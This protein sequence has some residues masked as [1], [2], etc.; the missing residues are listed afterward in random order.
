MDTKQI[1]KGSQAISRLQENGKF[2]IET[3]A[4]DIRMAGFMG[5]RGQ[6]S[7]NMTI[8]NILNGTAYQYR[9]NQGIYGFKAVNTAW[10]PSLDSSIANLNPSPVIGTDVITI[11]GTDQAGIALTQSMTSLTDTPQVGVNTL[12]NFGDIVMLSDCNARTVFQIT[13]SSPQA[14]GLLTHAVMSSQTPGN[15]STNLQ[16]LYSAD[17]MAYRMNARTY[18]IG[19]SA[20]HLG[21]YSLWRYCVPACYG[22]AQLEEIVDGVDDITILYGVDTDGDGSANKYV[23]AD[24]VNSANQWGFVSS[25][26]IQAL[27]STVQD[28]IVAKAQSYTYAGNVQNASDF[29]L[30]VPITTIVTLRNRVP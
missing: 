2:S 22:S 19:A 20:R 5:C 9:Y 17:A 7:A 27:F 3:M 29:R 12:F 13:E 11:W 1:S 10:S 4:N 24:T 25:V 18:Y 21:T 26:K 30:R 23:A 16:R 8:N 28:G 6:S 15:S 14:T